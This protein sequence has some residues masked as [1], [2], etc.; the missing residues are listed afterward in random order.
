[1]N[2]N[3]GFAPI[4]TIIIA[5]IIIAG[6]I[7][8]YLYLKNKPIACTQETKQCPDG[9]Y[10]SRIP[11]K[12]EFAE[13]PSVSTTISTSSTST[14]DINDWK[15][16]KNEK[17]GFEFK[18]PEKLSFIEKP[19][20][21]TATS[22]FLVDKDNPNYQTLQ[23]LLEEHHKGKINGW[24]EWEIILNSNQD[25][26][27]A[28]DSEIDMVS[29]NAEMGTDPNFSPENII[30]NP[31]TIS[32]ALGERIIF[33]TYVTEIVVFKK[34]LNLYTVAHYHAGEYFDDI[35]STFKFIK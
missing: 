12:C 10:V 30:K 28:V 3:K 32:G 6:G 20:L 27:E 1:M 8:G 29:A 25:L 34:G 15:T 16:Y 23:L 13:C 24:I 14:I 26:N 2:T 31:E 18:Y 7:G 5:V 17:L 22:T 4:I 11:P 33:N 9:S 19:L 21:R 35:L